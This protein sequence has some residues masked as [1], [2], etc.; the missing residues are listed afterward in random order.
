MTDAVFGLETQ[1][2]FPAHVPGSFADAD[3][4]A[5]AHEREI[6]RQSRAALSN[7]SAWGEYFRP[8]PGIRRDPRRRPSRS[9]RCGQLGDDRIGR[10][11]RGGARSATG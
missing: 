3:M 5:D 11:C 9:G 1:P 7:S 10:A 6:Q 4:L 2:A 8:G